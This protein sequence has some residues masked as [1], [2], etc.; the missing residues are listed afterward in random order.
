M[1]W[2]F[3]FISMNLQS[4]QQLGHQLFHPKKS[5]IRPVL[6]SILSVLILILPGLV[7]A[8]SAAIENEITILKVR[9]YQKDKQ[10]LI[11]SESRF[12]LPQTVIDAIHHEIPLSFTTRIELT[13]ATQT[14][15]IK[16]ERIRNV[17]EYST[18]L[19]AYGVNRLYALYNHRNQKAQSFTTLEE[20]LQTLATLQAFPIA[21]LSELHPEQ[22]YTLRMKISLDYW[23]LPAP[24]ILEALTTS[25]WQLESQWF[26]T[27]LQT[28]L[29]WQ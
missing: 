27:S 24:L 5:Q 10:L 17:V 1:T 2:L 25:T 20:A 11:D 19:Y 8:Q 12:N 29:S 4:G 7:T 13:E 22:R 3:A 15:G 18:D 28:P 9:D 16:Y 21:S 6:S 23:K 26:E 14:L